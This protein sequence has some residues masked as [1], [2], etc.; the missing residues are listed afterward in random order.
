MLYPNS[1]VSTADGTIYAGMRFF[2]ARLVPHSGKY[3]EGWL[4][5]SGCA[6][7]HIHDFDCICTK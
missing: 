6:K 5:P 3:A 4:V 1:I 7:F 2:V